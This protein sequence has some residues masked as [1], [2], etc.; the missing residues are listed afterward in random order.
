MMVS[1]LVI[2]M[3]RA[4]ASA[5]RIQEVLDIEP[6]VQDKPAAQAAAAPQ[7]RVAFENVQSS[8][9]PDRPRTRF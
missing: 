5:R 7:G 9:M 3:A 1:Q 4:E 8:A 6:D 2:Q